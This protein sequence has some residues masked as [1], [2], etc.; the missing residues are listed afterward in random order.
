MA[1]ENINQPLAVSGNGSAPVLHDDMGADQG[2]DISEK[3][4][5]STDSILGNLD[6]LRQVILVLSVAICVALIVL[7]TM[8]IK[9]PEMRP[10]GS[11]ET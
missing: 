7:V 11:Y 2:V 1:E 10:L 9:E 4:A 3:K 8:W 5:S 6:L